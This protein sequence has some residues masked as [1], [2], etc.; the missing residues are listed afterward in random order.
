MIMTCLAMQMY[1]FPQAFLANPFYSF[2]AVFKST[3]KIA[4]ILFMA[5]LLAGS[6]ILDHISIII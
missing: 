4:V 1:L 3:N 5:F 2:G 6:W